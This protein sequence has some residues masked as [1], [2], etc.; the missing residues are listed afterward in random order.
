[1]TYFFAKCFIIKTKLRWKRSLSN[2]NNI[3]KILIFLHCFHAEN[4]QVLIYPI[5]YFL[6]SF[7]LEH[8]FL[9]SV[10]LTLRPDNSLL[11]GMFYAL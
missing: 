7:S 3:N 11:W 1:M 5:M 10:L 8:S 9:I 6:G 2:A 4:D